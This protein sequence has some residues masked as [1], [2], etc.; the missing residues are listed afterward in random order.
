MIPSE[1]NF[2]K[3]RIMLANL[4]RALSWHS[5]PQVFF[6]S[7]YQ[8][9]SCG[10]ISIE[11]EKNNSRAK[12]TLT[13]QQQDKKILKAMVFHLDNLKK[14]AI[15]QSSIADIKSEKLVNTWTTRRNGNYLFKVSSDKQMAF[16]LLSDDADNDLAR[17]TSIRFGA[18]IDYFKE[19][20]FCSYLQNKLNLSIDQLR[21]IPGMD[22]TH[23]NLLLENYLMLENL[24][25]LGFTIQQLGTMSLKHI[26]LLLDHYLSLVS[27][28]THHVTPEQISQINYDKLKYFFNNSLYINDALKFVTIEQILGLNSQPKPLS[29]MKEEKSTER[30]IGHFGSS[31]GQFGDYITSTEFSTNKAEVKITHLKNTGTFQ[32]MGVT[33]TEESKQTFEK[34]TQENPPVKLIHQW[35]VIKNNNDQILYCPELRN[36]T[37]E[38]RG[39]EV[40][41]DILEL[42]MCEFQFYKEKRFIEFLSTKGCSI[43]RFHTLPGMTD[44][45]LKLL[46]ANKYAMEQLMGFGI[47]VEEFAN[48]DEPRLRHALKHSREMES[49]LK[50]VSIHDILNAK[51]AMEVEEEKSIRRAPGR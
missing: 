8:A 29:E 13:N 11:T 23:I 12:I 14:S 37:V 50:F 38:T 27:L 34:L 15:Y 49:A 17:L 22:E 35:Y 36:L 6:G 1:L 30:M 47:K 32:A 26:Q 42:A 4:F 21:T 7:S 3:G 16:S 2:I 19:I 10:G 40:P 39:L 9:T 5:D 18:I 28:F 45:K 41:K 33:L 46:F 20:Y 25:E 43:D 44:T 31:Q 24:I 48:I 51:V